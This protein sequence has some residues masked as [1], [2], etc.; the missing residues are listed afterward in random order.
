MVGTPPIAPSIPD[1]Q[2]HVLGTSDG[3]GTVQSGIVRGA[4]ST[5]KIEPLK[6]GNWLP[7]QNRMTSILKLQNVYGLTVGNKT[8]RMFGTS[9]LFLE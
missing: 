8:V 1:L 5:F 9:S 7:W 3:G 6:E 4:I 2:P